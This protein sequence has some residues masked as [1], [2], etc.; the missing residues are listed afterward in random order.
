MTAPSRALVP[1]LWPIFSLLF[2]ENLCA[3]H[4][5]ELMWLVIHRVRE[6]PLLL[7]VVSALLP[8]PAPPAPHIRTHNQDTPFWPCS[9]GSEVH[10]ERE[11]P[12]PNFRAGP[13]PGRVAAESGK[14]HPHTALC[15]GFPHYKIG[16]QGL[17]APTGPSEPLEGQLTTARRKP[18]WYPMQNNRSHGD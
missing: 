7:G 18:C 15:A 4:T 2:M 8:C 16:S 9:V 3:S 11:G 6:Q 14:S 5:D 1:T 17:P 13:A 12:D 10:Q